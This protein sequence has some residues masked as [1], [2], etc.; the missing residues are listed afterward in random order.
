[1]YSSFFSVHETKRQ[2]ALREL[3]ALFEHVGGFG[4]TI[5][6][7]SANALGEPHTAQMS[8]ASRG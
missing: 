7:D 6:Y 2:E 5:D 4:L 8:R 3:G 1:L